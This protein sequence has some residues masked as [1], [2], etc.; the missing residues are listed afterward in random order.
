MSPQAYLKS[1]DPVLGA[2]IDL[3][4]LPRRAHDGNYFKS[5]V[6]EIISQQLSGRVAD[7]IEARFVALFAP[8]A[9]PQPLDVLRMAD[10]ALR[11]AGLSYAKITYIK[12]ISRAVS[13]GAIDF[14]HIDQLTDEEVIT[15][16]TRVK[17]IGRWTAEMFLMFAMKRPDVFSYGDLGLRSAIKR[18]YRLRK[19]PS[20][21]KARELSRRWIPYRTL[22][23][24]YLWAS[25]K[26]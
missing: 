7:V 21:R 25:L 14:A 11:N 26:P 6:A 2:V 9:F 15:L 1:V 20:P 17:G 5:L 12:N 16:L 23:S 8:Q 22:A 19:H 10:A 3:V 18:L 4:R 13:D 24:R